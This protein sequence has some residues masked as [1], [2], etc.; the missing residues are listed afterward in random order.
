MCGF[1]TSLLVL[2]VLLLD[3][4]AVVAVVVVAVVAQETFFL[5]GFLM[6]LSSFSFAALVPVTF[7]LEQLKVELLL[8][9]LP[10]KDS[11]VV[12]DFAL[13]EML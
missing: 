3:V 8:P 7:P 6:Y 4:F 2:E 12:L 10:T 9:D 1:W 5:R 11:C 13:V